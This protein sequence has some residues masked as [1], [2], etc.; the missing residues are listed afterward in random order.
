[1]LTGLGSLARRGWVRDETKGTD[2]REEARHLWKKATGG[3]VLHSGRGEPFSAPSESGLERRQ[4][5]VAAASFSKQLQRSLRQ[6]GTCHVP[7][8]WCVGQV[9]AVMRTAAESAD[10]PGRPFL[11][12]FEAEKGMLEEYGVEL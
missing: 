9:G 7:G 1:M 2:G 3:S 4:R 11:E 8:T 12:S 5:V 10:G 6:H